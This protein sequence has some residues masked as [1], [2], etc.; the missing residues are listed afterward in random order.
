MAM[1][2]T[3]AA[4][5]SGTELRANPPEQRLRDLLRA[6]ACC[7]DLPGICSECALEESGI[8][9]R[10]AISSL[11][12]VR[13]GCLVADQAEVKELIFDIAD[14]LQYPR[15]DRRFVEHNGRKI[16]FCC[17]DCVGKFNADPEKYIAKVDAELKK[18]REV[19]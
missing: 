5:G 17:S 1:T 9:V 16:Y 3:D 11:R 8:G 19:K 18:L 12:S 10:N 15:Y 7:V 4:Y 2:P 13:E 14:P 6:L